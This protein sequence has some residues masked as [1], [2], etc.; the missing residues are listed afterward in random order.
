MTKVTAAEKVRRALEKNPKLSLSVLASIAGCSTSTASTARTEWRLFG[1]DGRPPVERGSRP[2]SSP[3][4]KSS[5]GSLIMV[6]EQVGARKNKKF[7]EL[8]R[9]P[10]DHQ[11][12]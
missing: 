2:K 11:G 1:K 12:G 9:L 3:D 5:A 6:D 10:S 4:K 7:R 8:W